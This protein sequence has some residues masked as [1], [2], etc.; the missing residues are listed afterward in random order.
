[1]LN[2]ADVESCITANFPVGPDIADTRLHI[3][4]LLGI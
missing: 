1:M 4:T 2:R 3:R